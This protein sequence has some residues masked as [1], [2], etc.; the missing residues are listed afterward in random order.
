MIKIPD[1]VEECDIGLITKLIHE[2]YDEN[3]I[4]EFKSEINESTKKIPITACAFAN[5]RGGTIVFGVNND[6]TNAVSL[7]QRLIGLIDSDDLKSKITN[8]LKSIKPDILLSNI[9]FK[10][11]NIRLLNGRVI[12]VM[13]ISKSTNTP[14][15]FEFKFYKRLANGN[16]PMDVEE[17]RNRILESA[18]NQTLLGLFISEGGYIR[19]QLKKMKKY[20]DDD[21]SI[22]AIP[23]LQYLDVTATSH[24]L[25][26]QSHLYPHE[27]QLEIMRLV[28]II[29]K[30]FRF[31]KP[32]VDFVN[33]DE[34]IS[35]AILE[36]HGFKTKEQ[37]VKDI[38]YDLTVEG[39]SKFE[40][41]EKLLNEKFPEPIK[42]S[43]KS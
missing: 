3:E 15:Q 2:G 11:S 37:W 31:D 5:T 1:N 20:F 9:Q 39:I 28:E 32:V 4:L 13:K 16:E 42:K 33:L 23:F 22:K 21:N 34:K 25:Y 40:L 36:K 17:V 26:N 6:R 7:D 30:L 19:D 24:F 18:K 29:T 35:N 27:V 41:L 10:E 12:V 38:L 43:D 14:H 8:Q